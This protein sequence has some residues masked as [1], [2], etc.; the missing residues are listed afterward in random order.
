MLKFKLTGFRKLRIIL[1]WSIDQFKRILIMERFWH[2]IHHRKNNRRK[3]SNLPSS[4]SCSCN[5]SKDDIQAFC[6]LLLSKLL[7]K[8]NL[9]QKHFFET[10]LPKKCPKFF[11]RI[12]ALA[13]Q[14]GQIKRK[15]IE[16]RAEF[17][18]KFSVPFWVIDFQEKLLLRFT[19][20]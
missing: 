20:L 14:M 13:S 4:R 6:F 18:Q 7:L 19:D 9:S 17:L 12:S 11:W 16:A 15:K 8:V 5:C 3:S 2:L 10:P 1:H